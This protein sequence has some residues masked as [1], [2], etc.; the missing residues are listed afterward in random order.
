[1][2]SAARV[3]LPVSGKPNVTTVPRFSASSGWFVGAK[4]KPPPKPAGLTTTDTGYQ[5]ITRELLESLEPATNHANSGTAQR[6]RELAKTLKQWGG[7]FTSKAENIKRVEGEW[8]SVRHG[9][10]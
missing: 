9:T 2:G 5:P 4:T 8:K 10:P 1:M 7:P 3:A 6:G